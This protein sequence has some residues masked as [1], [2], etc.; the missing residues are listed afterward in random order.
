MSDNEVLNEVQNVLHQ[1]SV[2]EPTP[3]DAP[4][5]ASQTLAHIQQRINTANQRHAPSFWQRF[6]SPAPA[7]RWAFVAALLIIF[8][9]AFTFPNVRAAASEFLSLFRVQKFAAISISP[10]QIA[11]LEQLSEEGLNPGKVTIYDEP[12]EQTPVNSLAEAATFTGLSPRT[13]TALG[14]PASIKVIGG[15]NGSLVI[16]LAGARAIIAAAGAD[17]LLLPDNV[18]G[19]RIQVVAFPG[20]EQNWADGTWLLQTESPLVQYPEEMAD[21]TILAEAFLQVMGLDEAEAKRLAQEIDWTSTL[22]LPLPENAVTFQEIRIDGGS[23]LAL[24][25]INSVNSA[26]LWEKEGVVY[27]LQGEKS[28]AE[29]QTLAAS[30]D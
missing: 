13:L 9:F 20:I 30:L 6:F 21:Q 12:G 3:L 2:L 1:L 28:P 19:A 24:Q 5:P 10:Q 14:D 16:D 26:L 25:D 15:G 23:G 8:M 11:L 22:L 4:K 18:D 7:R 17:P 29:L 27:L